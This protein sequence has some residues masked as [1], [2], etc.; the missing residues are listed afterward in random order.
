MPKFRGKPKTRNASR[1]SFA[2]AGS[3]TRSHTCRKSCTLWTEFKSTVLNDPFSDE[4]EVV[5]AR[6]VSLEGE[7][8]IR[9]NSLRV[10]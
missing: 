5:L 7:I 10:M 1:I 6:L 4:D 9:E 3:S 8:E 2:T